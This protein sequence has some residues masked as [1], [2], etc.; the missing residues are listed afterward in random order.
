MRCVRPFQGCG[1]P[2]EQA[3]IDAGKSRT[4]CDFTPPK[5]SLARSGWPLLSFFSYVASS[6]LG[7]PEMKT[8]F[9]FSSCH[10]DS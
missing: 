2:T 5:A 10:A 4:A 1:D 8:T 7:E 9:A 6:W 3:G